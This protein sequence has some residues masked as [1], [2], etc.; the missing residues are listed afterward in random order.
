MKRLTER[1]LV[2]VTTGCAALVLALL[3]TPITRVEGQGADPRNAKPSTTSNKN[4]AKPTTASKPTTPAR[5]P[6]DPGTSRP[7]FRPQ[8]PNIELVKIPP[9][10]FMMGSSNGGPFE[11]PVHLVT[12]SYSFYMG[13]YEVTQSQWQSVMGS[14]PS[15]FY[16]VN[17]PV[18][19]V[20]WNDA[21]G[22][23]RKLNQMNDA[24]TYRFPTEA[25]WEYACRAGTTR[26]Y[27]GPLGDV[28]WFSENSSHRTQAVGTKQPN[29]W[30][31]ADML[32]NVLEWCEDWHH[33]TYA[34][35]P[36]D[37]SAWLSGGE[38]KLRVLRGGSWDDSAPGLR[39]ASH[40]INPPDYRGGHVGFRVVAVTRTK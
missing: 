34:G 17:C 35:A 25:E 24:Y 30:G 40:V 39:C 4:S 23:I 29:A 11:Q 10:S 26:D 20:T 1:F 31:L 28:A 33:E 21:Q 15:A 9:G 19:A 38:Q 12:I 18:D 22:F 8:N 3:M 5:K 32:G 2:Y 13:K 16:C 37:G 27:A 36:T 7:A 14:D 6:V